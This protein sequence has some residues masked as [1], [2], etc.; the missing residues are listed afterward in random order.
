L[1]C[2]FCHGYEVKERTLGV[3]ANEKL[4]YEYCRM[5]H[6]WSKDLTLFTNGK[7]TLTTVQSEAL[8]QHGIKIVED[9]VKEIQHK[10]GQLT[11][12]VTVR[13]DLYPLDAVFSKAQIRQHCTIPEQLG[14]AL[15]E[16]GL[17]IVDEFQH[18]NVHGIFAAGDNNT[19]FRSVGL[20]IAG[21]IKAGA[22]L[23]HQLIEEEF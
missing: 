11:Q 13:G 1:H 12:L 5:I 16:H 21:G 22:M 4:A 10:E 2:P 9:E 19:M 7:S 15:N 23:N 18:T 14:C 17:L 20:A 6:H 8:R 3:I